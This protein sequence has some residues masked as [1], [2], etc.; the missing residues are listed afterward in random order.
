MIPRMLG[1]ANPAG[2][3]Q[4]EL[5]MGAHPKGE[6]LCIGEGKSEPLSR[7]IEKS[8]EQILGTSSFLK[9][10]SKL[11]FLLKV[12]AAGKPLSI[13][14]HPDLEQAKKGFARE[15]K[16]GI[17]IDAPERNYRD[18]NHKPELIYALTPFWALKGFRKIDEIIVEF[19]S[20]ALPSI[21]LQIDRFKEHPHKDGLKEFFQFLLTLDK[22]RKHTLCSEIVSEAEKREG[23]RYSWI[24]RL[25]KEYPGDI[26]ILC[27]LLLNCFCLEPGKAMFLNAGVLHAYL[28]GFG[29]ELMANS[30]NVLR[31]G[32]TPKHIDVPEL[33][34]TLTFDTGPAELLKPE[35]SG[36][37]IEIYTPPVDEFRLIKAE[38][39][40]K[41]SYKGEVK[42]NIEIAICT[43][44]RTSIT[45]TAKSGNSGVVNLS[46]GESVCIPADIPGYTIS[47]KGIV[48]IAGVPV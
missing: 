16:A 36:N 22:K 23:D 31:G 25:N 18:S 8:P 9:F 10:G 30:D 32:L 7:L 21:S 14:A 12:L 35:A 15:N 40:G 19:Y 5:W 44:G 38:L 27:P 37:A 41:N 48:F 3:P 4:A 13:Q 1:Q 11:P 47:G 24:L 17:P 26:G 42:R 29:I 43:R 34:K 20:L 2:T 46:Q 6:S 33:L 28:E 45:I 39:N